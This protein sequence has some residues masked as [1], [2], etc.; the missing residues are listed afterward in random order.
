MA[1]QPGYDAL[2]QLYATTFPTAFTTPLE[3][4][5]IEVFTETV[6]ARADD[7][8]V[9]DV[10]CGI[11]HVAAHLAAGGVQVIA[12]D[13]SSGM[14]GIGRATHPHI[15]FR[16][17]DAGLDEVELSRVDAILARFSL[18]HLSP[19][20][21]PAVLTS[22][23]RRLPAHAMVLVAAQSADEPGVH[24]FDHAVAR[25]WRWHPDTLAENL[26]AAGFEEHWR[27]LSHPDPQHRFPEVHMLSGIG[28]RTA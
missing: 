25:A 17:G 18:I 5:S 24:E 7:P 2:A 16:Y 15:D 9:V 3:R 27:T 11:G 21:M 6:R 10:G 8:V 4:H 13:P 20:L 22:W 19:E 28:G 12:V 26:A 14:V 1:H 23:R